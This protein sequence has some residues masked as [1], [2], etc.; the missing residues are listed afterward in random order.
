MVFLVFS[1]AHM[2]HHAKMEETRRIK[3]VGARPGPHWENADCL[4]KTKQSRA[5]ASLIFSVSRDG[6][7]HDRNGMK[8]NYTGA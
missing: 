7:Q 2:L 8:H 1:I 4:G 5:L 6:S 3:A